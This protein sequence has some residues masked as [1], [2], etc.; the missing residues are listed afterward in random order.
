MESHAS[1][2]DPP[3]VPSL[4]QGRHRPGRSIFTP[5]PWWWSVA[6]TKALGVEFEEISR[7]VEG[8]RK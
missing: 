2:L 8:P 5:D 4:A 6:P 7:V 1:S 3:R